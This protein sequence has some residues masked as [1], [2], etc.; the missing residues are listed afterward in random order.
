MA[1]ID[2]TGALQTLGNGL[3]G[4]LSEIAKSKYLPD[5]GKAKLE[6]WSLGVSEALVE[7][8]AAKVNGDTARYDAAMHEVEEYRKA[9]E[10]ELAAV[11]LR[12][13]AAGE[14]EARRAGALVLNAVIQI[15]SQ[16]LLAAV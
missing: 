15:G 14:A 11:E 16:L 8:G 7:A 3:V 12:T 10:A 2:L 13:I 9:V 5:N 6:K 4:T 1:T